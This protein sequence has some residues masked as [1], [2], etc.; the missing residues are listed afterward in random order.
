MPCSSPEPKLPPACRPGHP[1]QGALELKLDAANI[2]WRDC[3]A[4]LAEV[5]AEVDQ[6]AALVQVGW[7]Q[8]WLLACALRAWVQHGVDQACTAGS[9][10]LLV[11][12]GPGA[13]LPCHATWYSPAAAHHACAGQG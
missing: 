11:E 4:K 6:Q 10:Q 5:Q 12:L 8:V 13:L 7:V 3:Q 9:T 1:L 2:S